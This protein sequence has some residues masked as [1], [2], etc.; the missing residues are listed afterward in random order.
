MVLIFV[1]TVYRQLIIL[2][3]MFAWGAAVFSYYGRLPLLGA[4]LASVST[5][6][7][8]GLYVPNGGNFLTLNGTEA[9]EQGGYGAR[10]DAITST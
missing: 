3:A 10:E 7:T 4:F 2:G 8:I 9:L 1:K 5:I 6:A